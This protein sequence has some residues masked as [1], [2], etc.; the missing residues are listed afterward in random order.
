M[1][2]TLS[3]KVWRGGAEGSFSA[4]EVPRQTSQTVLDVVTHIQRHLEPSLSYRFACRV[5]MCGSCAMTVNGKACWT[6]RTHVAKVAGDG[7]TLE[8]APLSNLPVIK[9]LAT[10]MTSFFDKWARAKGSF[11]GSTTRHE[12]FARV[13]PDSPERRAAN[14]GIECIGCGVCVAS[15]D[16]VAWRP[17][18]LGPAA[19]NR[20][21][22][23]VNDVRDTQR[24]ER[25][26]A[27]AG[28]AGCHACHTQG[29]CTERCPKQLAPTVAIAGL[30]RTVAKAAVRGEL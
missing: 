29:S 30:K 27:V 20:A 12:D 4:Y 16:V 11:A 19:L 13:A 24:S 6:C 18:Y 15:C 10:D 5:G 2:P 1:Q 3:V 22:T 14:A 9:D 7:G 8:I 25:L 21:W 23:L 26:R 17:D 28:D